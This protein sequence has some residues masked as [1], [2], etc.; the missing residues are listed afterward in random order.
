MTHFAA[1]GS[2]ITGSTAAD[3]LADSGVEIT[4]GASREAQTIAIEAVPVRG[5]SYRIRSIA[6]WMSTIVVTGEM[7]A[8]SLW[9]LLQI[10]FNRVQLQHLGYPPY[11]DLILG[12]W[13]LAG[14][15]AVIAPRFPRLKEWAYAGFF[16][17]FSGAVASQLFRGEGP[18]TWV[19]PLVLTALTVVSWALRP[20][21][22]RLP[23]TKPSSETRPVDWAIAVTI[24]VILFVLS[25]LT[26]P[27]GPPPYYRNSDVH[28]AILSK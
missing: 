14:A 1:I 5:R 11:L 17:N 20:A 7:V 8:G 12:P 3:G 25:C 2:G 6:Y 21:D 15:A 24:M 27:K 4:R 23:D 13:K 18:S 22:R 19:Y 16:F 26:I 9:A 28:P 10:E